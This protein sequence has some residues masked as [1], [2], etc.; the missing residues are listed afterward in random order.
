MYLLDFNRIERS[1]KK[2]VLKKKYHQKEISSKRNILKRKNPSLP[3]CIKFYLKHNRIARQGTSSLASCRPAAADDKHSLACNISF[4]NR[5]FFFV[6]FSPRGA[7][8][9][10]RPNLDRS[11]TREGMFT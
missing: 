3:R 10:T 11:K 6:V 1:S 5:L 8:P 9:R 4:S 2:I 7:T